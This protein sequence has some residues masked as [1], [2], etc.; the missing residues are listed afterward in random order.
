MS[1]G[2]GPDR[3]QEPRFSK[4]LSLQLFDEN[5]QALFDPI[6]LDLSMSGLCFET[7]KPPPIGSALSFRI[8]IPKHGFVAG[9]GTLRWAYEGKD[10]KFLCGI[11]FETFGWANQQT[12]K[13]YLFPH[14]SKRRPLEDLD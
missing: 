14:A 7:A 2:S 13:S 12:L 4:H 3:R 5:K 6:M 10:A 1:P 8:H 11:H 9:V